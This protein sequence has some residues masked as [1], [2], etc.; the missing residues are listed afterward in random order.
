[1]RR[2]GGQQSMAGESRA[3]GEA[4]ELRLPDVRVSPEVLEAIEPN[5]KE[6][7]MG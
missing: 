1:M 2:L 3:R 6:N 4:W 7:H 5:P